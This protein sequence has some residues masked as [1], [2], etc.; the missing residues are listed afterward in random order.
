M[1]C[2]HLQ[3]MLYLCIFVVLVFVSGRYL[4]RVGIV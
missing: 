3:V 2:D 1:V 4:C